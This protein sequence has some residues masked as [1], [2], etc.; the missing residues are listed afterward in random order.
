[1]AFGPG[2]D[3]GG[4]VGVGWLVDDGG[5]CGVWHVHGIMAFELGSLYSL[6]ACFIR[7]LISLRV[8]CF[9]G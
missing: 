8:F 5:G 6:S 1:M 9:C 4:H 2:R 7:I 3:Q